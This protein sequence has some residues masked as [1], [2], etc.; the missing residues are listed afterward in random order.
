MKPI[1]KEPRHVDDFIDDHKGHSYA[2]WMLLHFRLS[3]VCQIDFAPFIYGRFLF[4]DYQGAR[5]R[6]IG[7][8]RMGDV[9]LTSKL[10]TDRDGFPYEHRVAVDECSKWGAEA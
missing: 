9:W 6:V 1:M 3:A 7:A 8:S 5:H 4:C 10:E 2:R